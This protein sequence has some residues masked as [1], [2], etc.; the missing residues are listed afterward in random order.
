MV[1]FI[2]FTGLVSDPACSIS[3]YT[4]ERPILVNPSC[5][6]WIDTNYNDSYSI[7]P[8]NSS[9]LHTLDGRIYIK[10]SLAE[11][12]EKFKIYKQEDIVK[13]NG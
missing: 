2:E 7:Y 8:E 10:E 13:I 12:K 4:I 1:D 9:C 6:K 11:V 3:N 5:I